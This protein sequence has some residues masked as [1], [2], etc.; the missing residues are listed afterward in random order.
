M[1]NCLVKKIACKESD[2]NA[3][4]GREKHTWGVAWGVSIG[5]ASATLRGETTYRVNATCATFTWFGYGGWV[6]IKRSSDLD[7]HCGQGWEYNKS[8]F[9]QC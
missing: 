7:Q 6:G 5:Y 4:H 3:C 8:S 9:W 1:C 2:Y